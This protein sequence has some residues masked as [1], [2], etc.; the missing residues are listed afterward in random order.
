MGIFDALL[1]LA[2]PDE[3]RERAPDTTDDDLYNRVG[4]HVFPYAGSGER[5]FIPE[6]TE[7]A[8]LR[9]LRDLDWED[10]LHQ[11]VVVREPGVSMETSG[12]LLPADGLSVVYQ[13]QASGETV[14]AREVPET[15]PELEAIQLA[16]IQGGDAWQNVRDYY[17]L[18][19][20]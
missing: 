17:R 7:D 6:L 10:G 3:T 9:A 12:S 19:S 13:D 18:P 16:F 14:M 8:V 15:I 1:R 2:F 5:M 20:R 11:V 4:I